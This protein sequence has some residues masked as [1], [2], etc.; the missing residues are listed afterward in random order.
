VLDVNNDEQAA[1]YANRQ[2]HDVDGGVELL[3]PKAPQRDFKVVFP[4]V[5]LI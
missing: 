4:H 2:A 1:R 3:P 5:K